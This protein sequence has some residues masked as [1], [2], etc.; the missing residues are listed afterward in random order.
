MVPILVFDIE[1]VPDAAGLR[2][3]WGLDG[4]DDA[5]VAAALARRRP[6]RR[7]PWR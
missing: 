6:P 7:S 3:A 5:V 1:T 2:A 4:D